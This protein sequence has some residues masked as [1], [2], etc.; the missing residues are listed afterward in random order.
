MKLSKA[1]KIAKFF[2]S[3]KTFEKMKQD[4]SQWGFTCSTCNERTSIWEIGGIRYKAKGNP[5]TR[6]RCPKCETISI[7][8]I[9]KQG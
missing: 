2:S 7:Q 4:S 3:A 9:N 6:I 5:R 1:Q 8:R